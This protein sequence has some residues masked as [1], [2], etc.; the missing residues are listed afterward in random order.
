MAQ[1]SQSSQDFDDDLTQILQTQ[2]EEVDYRRRLFKKPK[3]AGSEDLFAEKPS[4]KRND[5]GEQSQYS[6]VIILGEVK[7]MEKENTSKETMSPRA[8]RKSFCMRFHRELEQL[9]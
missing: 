6:E 8:V 5:L 3:I 1:S 7:R 9:L 4:E 2:H